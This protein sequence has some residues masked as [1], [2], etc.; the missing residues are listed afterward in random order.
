MFKSTEHKYCESHRCQWDDCG[1]PREGGEFCLLH[2]C[3]FEGCEDCIVQVDGWH[4]EFH[5]C[6]R[7]CC[8]DVGREELDHK[9]FCHWKEDERACIKAELSDENM[10]LRLR[11]QELDAKIARLEREKE[12][13]RMDQQRSRGPLPN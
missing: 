1:F 4:C 8:R 7:P 12:Q 10:T 3:H 2:S 9:C 11:I 5:S 6:L 13:I